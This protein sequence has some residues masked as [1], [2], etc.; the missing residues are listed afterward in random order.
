MGDYTSNV[1]AL[2]IM[3][4]KLADI[5]KEYSLKRLS[6]LTIKENPVQ[7][8]GIWWNEAIEADIT[9]VNAM[10]LATSSKEAV[11]SARIVLLKEFTQE[12]FVF[13]TNYNSFKGH[14]LAENP[15]ACLVFYWKELESMLNV[16]SEERDSLASKQMKSE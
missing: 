12:G 13:F 7:Q 2:K 11:P 9:D 6:E 8:F 1:S 15:K 14:E 4:N 10:T 5:R 16:V 3:Q